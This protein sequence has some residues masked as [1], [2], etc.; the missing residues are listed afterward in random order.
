M[1]VF[2]RLKSQ[3]N[4]P[5]EEQLILDSVRQMSRDRIAP[6]AE[7]YDESG[8]FPWDNVKDINEL[9]LNAMFVPEE[10]GG[11][12]MNISQYAR[13]IH[14]LSHAMPAFRSLITINTGMFC[15]AIKE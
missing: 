15:S 6:R 12:G 11:A 1:L 9:G 10:F 13:T 3:I 14:A 4:L 5:E 7:A 8:D 2:D